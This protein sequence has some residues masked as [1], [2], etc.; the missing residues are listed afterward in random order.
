MLEQKKRTAKVAVPWGPG[1]ATAAE[2]PAVGTRDVMNFASSR[3]ELV[4]HLPN[5]NSS[6]SFS[7][8]RN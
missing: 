8:W 1:E 5:A 4:R 2:Q 7:S 3:Q 6:E